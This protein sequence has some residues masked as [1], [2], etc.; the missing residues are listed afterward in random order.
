MIYYDEKTHD[1]AFSFD[2]LKDTDF[3]NKINSVNL[4]E[5]FNNKNKVNDFMNKEI[6][7]PEDGILKFNMASY[8]LL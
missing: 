5:Y 6:G 1:I 8:F 7:D 2:M 3:L 4:Y